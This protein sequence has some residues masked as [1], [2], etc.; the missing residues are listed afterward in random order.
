MKVAPYRLVLQFIS[1][2][3]QFVHSQG[4]IHNDLKV[5]TVV[6]EKR[7]DGFNPVIIDFGKSSTAKSH[8]RMLT[9]NE[10]AKYLSKYRHV[11]PE[12]VS[13]GLPSIACILLL[14]L[15]TFCVTKH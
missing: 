14:K 9:S 5:K 4:I 6:L 8:K 1:D 3:L 15:F 10:R 7:E 11:A 13:G 2:A 12:L